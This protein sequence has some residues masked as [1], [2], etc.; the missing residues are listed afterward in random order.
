MMKMDSAIDYLSCILFRFC[1]SIVRLLP[2]KMSFFLG[3]RLGDLCYCFDFKHKVLV[4]ANLKKAI[5]GNLSPSSISKLSRKFYRSFGQNLMEIFLIPLV[6]KEYMKKYVKI[7]GLEYVKEGFKKGKGVILL[8]VHEGS[9]EFSNIIC[10]NLGFPFLLLVRDQR[11]PRLNALLNSYR[12]SRG[13]RIIQRRNG[14]RQLIESLRNNQSIGM[15][16]DQGGKSGFLVDFFG[17]RASMPVGAVRLALKYGP[18]IL[19]VFFVRE[20]G[21]FIRVIVSPPFQI[22][23]TEEPERDVQENLAR[24]VSIFEGF[25]RSYP[26]E[27]LWSY[28]IWKYSDERKILILNDGKVGHLRQSQAVAQIISAEL[29]SRGIKVHSQELRLSFAGRLRQIFLTLSSLPGSKYSCQGCLWCL[30]QFIDRES[31]ESLLSESPDM[32]ISCGSSL[33]A[34]NLILAREN[35]AKSIVIM[36]PSFLS[37]R[38][39]DLVIMSRH[40]NPPRRKNIAV[41]EGAL[42]LIDKPYLDKAKTQLARST[43]IKDG[44]LYLGVLLG[45]DSKNFS[46]D[47]EVIARVIQEIKAAAD[48]LDAGLLVTTSRRTSKDIEMLVNEELQDYPRC[49]LLVIANEKNI[50]EAVGGIL[51]L[52][53][54]VVI[55]PESI[56]MVSEAVSS[57]K[58]VFVFESKGL[59]RKHRR[60][61]KYF[62]QKKYLSLVEASNLKVALR[63]ACVEQGERSVPN[64]NALIT[65]AVKKI[66]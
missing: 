55:S 12:S 36:R 14:T 23:K 65:E 46:L 31:S 10:A 56:S 62:A 13:C 27:Y 41:T 53:S 58:P 57:R 43:G 45:G 2:L 11:F 8:A 30:R 9:W 48:Q 21:P 49:R 1:G 42:N 19:P 54:A 29:D 32:V 3:R 20:R 16:A 6:D 5:G 44:L 35:L 33:A 24:I 59:G 18:T 66:L 50:P 64:N 34:A 15:T 63:K 60:F 52:S 22:R 40:D 7:E 25:I 38:K 51:G 39:F 28:K 47:R 61:L 37:A 4:Y 26:Q 17:K